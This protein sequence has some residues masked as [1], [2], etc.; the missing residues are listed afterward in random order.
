MGF[1]ATKSD[2]SLLYRSNVS[3][4]VFL[5]I[6]VD[7]II[8]TGTSADA[9]SE[10]AGIDNCKSRPTPMTS[11][12]KLP[13]N[14][15]ELFANPRLY[16]SI[17]GSLQYLTMTR[18]ELAYLVNKVC[19]F[20][21]APREHHWQAVNR[22]LRYLQGSSTLGLHLQKSSNLKITGYSDSDWASDPDDR[23]STADFCVYM[24]PNLIS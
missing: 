21:Q 18:P 12:L 13:A 23:K 16:R 14:E 1:A 4:T 5:L 11:N 6:Y 3:A 2:V 10:K 7:D 20:I 22:I 17:V 24:V 9:I 8:V 15:G 19:Q